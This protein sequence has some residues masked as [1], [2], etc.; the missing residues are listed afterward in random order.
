MNKRKII[1]IRKTKFKKYENLF[2]I[3]FLLFI[4]FH[5]EKQLQ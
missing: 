4:K 5:L 1:V 2:G 3:F